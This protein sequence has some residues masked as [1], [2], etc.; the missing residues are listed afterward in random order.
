MKKSKTDKVKH[1][2]DNHKW[3]LI[4]VMAVAAVASILLFVRSYQRL[5]QSILNERVEAV[6]QIGYL[7]SDKVTMLKDS[8]LGETRQLVT[9][10]ENSCA[11]SM[12]EVRRMFADS[13]DFL[14]VTADGKFHA[15][16]GSTWLIKDNDLRMNIVQGADVVST[17]ATIQTRGDY[18]LFSSGLDGVT[19]DGVEYV[20]LVKPVDARLY[21][22]VATIPLY[23]G[24]GAS[25]VIDIHGFIVMRPQMA[26][27]NEVFK[28]Y[29]LYSILNQA[30][31]ARRELEQLQNAVINEAPYQCI[32][33]L[34]GM[35]WLI[36]SV[37]V[38][39]DRGIVIAVP[40]SVTAKD[41]YGQMRSVILLS[42]LVVLI[43]AALVLS[44]LLFMMKRNQA[45]KLEQAKARAKNDF[46]DK[47]SHDIRT[48]LNAIIGMHELALNSP[49][50]KEVVLDCLKKAK[51]SSSYL[52]SII[53]DVLDMSKIESGKMTISRRQFSMEELLDHVMQMEEIPARE[54]NLSLSL[55]IES[56][57]NTD[58]I[59]DSVRIRQCLINII[60]NAIKFTPEGGRIV[61]DYAAQ[62][63]DSKHSRIRFSIQDTGIGMSEDFL[64]RIFT[65]FEQE[66]SSLT[67]AYV[68]SGLGLSIVNSLV[69]L[70]GGDITVESEMG[71]GSIFT[72][73]IPLSTIP[74]SAV[75]GEAESDKELSV[76][77][78]NRR[79]LVAEDND[80]NREIISMLLK[81]MG[82]VVDTAVHGRDAAEQFAQS[83]PGYYSLILMDIQMPVMDG[84]EA[85]K[86]IRASEHPDSGAIPIV[87]LSA[88][89]FDDDTQRSLDA[90]MQ[91]HLAKPV[92]LAEL[93][94]ILKKYVM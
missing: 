48:P 6:Q 81:E 79:V 62:P 82:F 71:I 76:R 90:G 70:M 75:T 1:T 31:I 67:S 52:V 27:A 66:F 20:G 39:A 3:V 30:G 7:L 69:S 46:L 25:Y 18:W 43:L 60:S 80:I 28:G 78:R 88:N 50:D 84:L 35:T 72:I 15:P 32:T 8:Y 58:F 45:V 68:G 22:D 47:M 51:M 33:D 56:P 24:I 53:N 38:D 61:V 19:L 64:S 26:E 89:A 74:M 93:K 65:P 54:K 14:L 12:E 4:S 23:S 49:D 86:Q 37:S 63:I 21:A 2:S 92:D 73:T 55:N 94:R 34:G 41:T 57:V 87:A 44:T 29:N 9:L 83:E 17:F 42:A 91:A 13:G 11:A 59:G 16:D 77:I 36:Q 5:N 40:I 10:L 85:T